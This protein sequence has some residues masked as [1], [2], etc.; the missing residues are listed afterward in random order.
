M[1]RRRRCEALGRSL[2]SQQSIWHSIVRMPSSVTRRVVSSA[3]KK[4]RRCEGAIALNSKAPESLNS[5]SSVRM[6]TITH[7]AAKTSAEAR[8]CSAP[9]APP[10]PITEPLPIMTEPIAPPLAPPRPPNEHVEVAE[11]LKWRLFASALW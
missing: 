4:A 6:K 3:N 8:W 1:Y 11:L 7:A 9:A 2:G 5:G 10:P